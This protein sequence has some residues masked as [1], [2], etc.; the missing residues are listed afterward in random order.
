MKTLVGMVLMCLVTPGV[1]AGMEQGVTVLRGGRL[2]DADAGTVSAPMAVVM[3]GGR[4]ERV[5]AAGDAL[6]EGATVVDVTGKF[7]LP[8]LLATHVHVSDVDGIKP[9]TYTPEN[10]QRQL[11]LYARYGITS[12]WSLGGEQA[13][14]FEIRQAQRAGTVAGSRLYLA[15]EIVASRTPDAAKADV[16]RIAATQPDWIKIRVDDNLGTSQKMPPEVYKA[17]IDEAHARGLRVAAHIFYLDDAK[18]LAQAGVDM[19]GHSVRDKAVDE[20]FIAMMKARRIPY[21]P[22]LT[23][24]VATFVYE[25]TPPFFSDPFFLREADAAMV[26]RLKEPDR[27]AAMAANTGARAYK[28]AL[29]TA[30]A[31]L[32]KLSDAGVVITMGTDSGAFPERFQGY[33]EHLEMEMMVQAGMTPAQVLRSA[34]TEAARAMKVDDLGRLSAGARAD[35]L[36]LDRNPLENI[37][38]TRA[39]DSVWIGGA[40]IVR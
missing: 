30:M 27:Q 10:T 40:R 21:S 6:A 3:R 11:A 33:F 5:A 14:A 25:S 37:L 34:T 28:A 16:A 18:A 8:G 35:V 31:N 22:T 17:V 2:V 23:R 1:I 15:G 4:I 24:E 7:L 36:V 12:V 39:I 9:R 19:I 29:P 13:P 26:A 20:E 38:H 32:K